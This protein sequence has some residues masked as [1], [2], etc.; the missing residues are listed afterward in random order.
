M[1]VLTALLVEGVPGVLHEQGFDVIDVTAHL[2]I[3]GPASQGH[4]GPGDD[5]DEAPGELLEGGGV[6]LA[7]ELV[8]DAGGDF[9]FRV[10]AEYPFLGSSTVQ[11]NHSATGT[12]GDLIVAVRFGSDLQFDRIAVPDGR[13]V[14]GRGRVSLRGARHF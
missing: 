5:I 7:G 1:P 12:D 13:I 10:P 6:A 4:Q 9:R 2:L 3:V 8:G 11:V 14:V